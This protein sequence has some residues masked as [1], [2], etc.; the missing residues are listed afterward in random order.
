MSINNSIHWLWSA[1]FCQEQQQY[2]LRGIEKP[3]QI[4]GACE[5]MKSSHHRITSLHYNTCPHI[6]VTT[7][8]TYAATGQ[9]SLAII[10]A[11]NTQPWLRNHHQILI[12]SQSL[13]NFWKV[14]KKWWLV[15]TK[16]LLIGTTVRWK[17]FLIRGCKSAVTT[18]QMCEYQCW[19]CR[20]VN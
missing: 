10:G 12:F 14:I 20:K 13:R 16:L 1:V 3:Y 6:T 2:T 7:H 4:L 8:K 15:E 19:L 18:K 5:V 17:G 9:H 11:S